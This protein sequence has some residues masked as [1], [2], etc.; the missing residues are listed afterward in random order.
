MGDF[1]Q[2]FH[3]LFGWFK[4]VLLLAVALFLLGWC[5]VIPVLS[6]LLYKN[7]T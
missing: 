3:N 1:E 6:F 2:S 4:Y 7:W 5:V